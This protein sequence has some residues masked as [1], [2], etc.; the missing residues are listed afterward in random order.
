MRLR[1]AQGRPY[2]HEDAGHESR[3][4][5]VQEDAPVETEIQPNRK[6]GSELERASEYSAGPIS[7][8]RAKNGAEGG[9][10]HGLG[11][12]LA[13]QPP[14][15]RT[16]SRPNRHLTLAHSCAHKQHVRYIHA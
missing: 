1:R 5:A 6:V 4:K 8:D 16:H 14:S 15:S 13:N 9:K 11:Q 3:A 7:K 10:H 2:T 12:C